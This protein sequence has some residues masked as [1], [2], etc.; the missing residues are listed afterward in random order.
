M[1]YGINVRVPTKADALAAI[2]AKFDEIIANQPVHARDREAVLNNA[3]S[4][5]ALLGDQPEGTEVHV[6]LNGYVSWS[7]G[8]VETASFNSVKVEAYASFVQPLPAVTV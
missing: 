3:G 4:V 2:T 5:V 7:S 8:D 1:S 6:S